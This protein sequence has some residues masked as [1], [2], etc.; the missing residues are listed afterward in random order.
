MT[1][2]ALFIYFNKEGHYYIECAILV[3]C[4]GEVISAFIFFFAI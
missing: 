4:V 1:R 2:E 3:V